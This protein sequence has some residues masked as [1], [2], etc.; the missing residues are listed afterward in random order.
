MGGQVRGAPLWQQ[1]RRSRPPHTHA[2]LPQAL[3]SALGG[4]GGPSAGEAAAQAT[5]GGGGYG[6]PQQQQQ[7][8]GGGDDHE[9]LRRIL[10]YSDADIARMTPDERAAVVQVGGTHEGACGDAPLE[11]TCSDL[12]PPPLPLP[13]QVRN[14]LSW[15]DARIAALPP[16]ERHELL[17]LRAE[18]QAA[19]RQMGGPL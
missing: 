13:P 18:L 5:Y 3:P 6:P 19:L 17:T 16:V 10:A 9:Q 15:P 2:L 4:G 14:A 8:G 11:A 7:Q 1:R 12:L